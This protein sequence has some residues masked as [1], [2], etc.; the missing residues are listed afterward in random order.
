MALR[1]SGED[2][3]EAIL[4]I[5]RERGVVRSVDIAEHLGVT[6][7]SVSKAVSALEER[8]YIEV[9]RRDVR[10]TD[11][12]EAR[13]RLVLEQHAFFCDL[14]VAAGVAPELA[15][16]EAC[17]T[18]STASRMTPLPGCAPISVPACKENINSC[19][20]THR[21]GFIELQSNR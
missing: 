21:C 19:S 3:L 7:A 5:R 4:V 10:L 17:P 9:V 20:V 2:Y 14:L 1:E 18:W 12:G 6:K 8:G 13:A 11:K 15:A 16:E